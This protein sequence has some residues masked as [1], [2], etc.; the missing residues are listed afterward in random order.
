M[1]AGHVLATQVSVMDT[2]ATPLFALGL[3]VPADW[4]GQPVTEAFVEQ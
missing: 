1:R 2:A 4:E 3:D